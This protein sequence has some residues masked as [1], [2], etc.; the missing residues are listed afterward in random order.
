VSPN[1]GEHARTNGEPSIRLLWALLIIILLIRLL[2]M[3][4]YPIMDTTEARYAE[5]SRLMLVSGD[6]VMP[7]FRQGVP[8]WGKPPLFAWLTAGSFSLLGVGE[9][10]ARLPHFLLGLATLWLLVPVSRSELP[11]RRRLLAVVI[12]ASTP[13]FFVSAGTVMTESGLLFSTTLCMTG[14]WLHTSGHDR[15]WG[16]VF[17]AGL[18]LGMLAKGPIAVVMTMLPLV[19]WSLSGRHWQQLAGLPWLSGG[20]LALLIA[21]PW[22]IAAESRS[23]GFLEY[24][25]VGEHFLRFVQP[26]W[27]GDLYGK[28]HQEVPG[29]IWLLWFQATAAWG[30]LMAYVAGRY[31]LRQF[32]K[33]AWSWP[34][35]SKWQ[36]YLAWWMLTPLLFFT[37]SGNILWTYVLSGMPAMA[38]L[39]TSRQ[40][41]LGP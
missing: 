12:L 32:R 11:P 28:A 36:S 29:M 7:H 5:I 21:L 20:L 3:A 23:P 13:L 8:F 35:V 34:M 39:I 33:G 17:F 26:G 16:L 31:T 18:G 10:A 41:C 30:V 25:L 2:T 19:L 24:F 14:F 27:N 9:F 6:W 38:L 4:L 37:F 22:Y 1:R 40:D 15:V